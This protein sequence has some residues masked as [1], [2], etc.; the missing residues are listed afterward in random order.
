MAKI[1]ALKDEAIKTANRIGIY[2]KKLLRLE[3]TKTLERLLTHELCGDEAPEQENLVVR[4]RQ[5]LKSKSKE[6]SK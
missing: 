6:D 1:R 3:S 2:D 4:L 5:K